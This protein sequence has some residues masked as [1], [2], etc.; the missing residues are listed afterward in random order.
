M[1]GLL[2]LAQVCCNSLKAGIVS[3]HRRMLELVKPL[4]G[5][6]AGLVNIENYDMLPT[7]FDE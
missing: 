7:T 1:L 4:F 6:S 3:C 5:A 2:R